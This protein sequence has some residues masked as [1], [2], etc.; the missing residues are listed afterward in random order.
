MAILSDGQE[1]QNVSDLQQQLVALENHVAELSFEVE[2][3]NAESMMQT[4]KHEALIDMV[5]SRETQKR[6]GIAWKERLVFKFAEIHA[7]S[8]WR[9]DVNSVYRHLVEQIEWQK[10]D[11]NTHNN[12][13][14]MYF[15]ATF[16]PERRLTEHGRNFGVFSNDE[17]GKTL[18]TS[19]RKLMRMDIL[20]HTTRME[21][22][23]DL[24]GR[25]LTRF[26]MS[27]N[28]S[29]TSQGLIFG[30]PS[31]FVYMLRFAKL[32]K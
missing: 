30:K 22:A 29:R 12:N 13:N 32:L 8:V 17:M 5:L 9:G 16:N 25:L 11:N 28:T 27:S 6:N 21:K 3:L 1:S 19:K 15:G 31:Y 10:D 23:A 4:I 20:Y 18:L 7:D 2:S 26:P 14:H 24:E